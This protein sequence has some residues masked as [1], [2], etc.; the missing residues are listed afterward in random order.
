[1][2]WYNKQEF[3]G[4]T[5]AE[6]IENCT[7][8]TNCRNNEDCIGAEMC[9]GYLPGCS[10]SEMSKEIHA[11]EKDP[12]K[13]IYIRP[14]DPRNH[15]FC[16]ESADEAINKCSLDTHCP[17]SECPKGQTCFQF[18]NLD[19]CD[20]YAMW[21]NTSEPTPVPLF[22][23]ESPI[24]NNPIRQ[25][26]KE[27]IIE[28][29]EAPVEIVYGLC[30]RDEEHLQ[31]IYRSATECSNVEPCPED[32]TCMQDIDFESAA[33]KNPSK[34]PSEKPSQKPL[35]VP[36][37]I[38]TKAHSKPFFTLSPV[39]GPGKEETQ[40][41]P[42]YMAST[43]SPV[44]SGALVGYQDSSG[45]PHFTVSSTPTYAEKVRTFY[46]AANIAELEKSCNSAVECSNNVKCPEG[47]GCIHYDCSKN[48]N[49]QQ[50][51]DILGNN[52]PDECPVDF[53]GYTSSSAVNCK[54]YF[55]CDDG[56]IGEANVCDD[57]LKYDLLRGMCWYENE[58]DSDCRGPPLDTDEPTMQPSAKPTYDKS[59]LTCPKNYTGTTSSSDS[60]CKV[61]YDCKNGEVGTTGTCRDKLKYDIVRQMC[62][63]EDDVNEWCYGPPSGQSHHEQSELTFE[64]DTSNQTFTCFDGQTGWSTHD[65]CKT[66]FWCE[67]GVMERDI[68]YCIEG[69][70][71]DVIHGTCK[72]SSD[73]HCNETLNKD[74]TS[75]DASMGYTMTDKSYA[76]PD[77]GTSHEDND[78]GSEKEDWYSRTQVYM[79]SPGYCLTPGFG[80]LTILSFTYIILY[81]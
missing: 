16:G 6:A 65:G 19:G 2:F 30:A 12:S 32:L 42:S 8:E 51:T 78:R 38:P 68:L 25:P 21:M 9:H 57:G 29:T 74:G 48:I 75:K 18:I 39:L 34:A 69:L 35:N 37:L 5:W 80:V 55:E 49:K 72:H 47:Q 45:Q 27:P 26:T 52:I 22:L 53:V 4:E 73:V 50:D 3:C 70:L 81:Y 61:Y 67:D 43:E 44:P 79:N 56:K 54:L 28:P 33:Q 59:N 23:T 71:F 20:A 31:Q 7:P 58:V 13:Q 64:S 76:W 40:T 24:T 11:S 66:Y 77:T 15:Y 10:L 62:W 1:M 41:L 14:N 17:D 60:N 36:S 46:C 63:Y